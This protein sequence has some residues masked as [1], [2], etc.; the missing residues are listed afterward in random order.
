MPLRT[1]K[2]TLT[3]FR[4]DLGQELRSPRAWVLLLSYLLF[5][6]MMVLPYVGISN[7]FTKW[8]AQKQ[9]MAKMALDSTQVSLWARAF[10][11]LT[12]SVQEGLAMAQIPLPAL[13]AFTVASLFVPFLAMLTSSDIIAEDLRSGHIRYLALRVSRASLLWGRLLSRTTLLAITVFAGAMGA[14]LLFIWKLEGLP[15]GAFFHFL[16]FGLLLVALVPTYVALAALCSTLVKSPFFALLLGIFLLLAFGVVDL[17]SDVL[18]TVTPNHYK[19]LL[20]SPG[21][22]WMGLLALVGFG[23]GYAALAWLRLRT[24]DL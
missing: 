13:Y 20:Y 16:R 6:L 14:Y 4:D 3:A 21:R 8:L 19:L 24:R 1:L 7:L 11:E 12:G 15:E 9:P 5:N 22:W 2:E 17:A 18:G 10:T 23:G